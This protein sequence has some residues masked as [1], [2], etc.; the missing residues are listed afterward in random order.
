M[1]LGPSLGIRTIQTQQL[2]M[3]PQLQQAIKLLALTNLELEN[4][5]QAEV[6]NNP[7]LDVA[8]ADREDGGGDPDEAGPATPGEATGEGNEELA[9][10][11]RLIESGDAVAD[12]PLEADYWGEGDRGAD[13]ERFTGSLDTG[14]EGEGLADIESL[15]EQRPTLAEHLLQQAAAVLT[16]ANLAV[17][18][19][20]I[21]QIDDSGYF[22]GDLGE[23]AAALGVSAT[24][25]E[26]ILKMIQGFDPTGVGART[27]GECLELQAREAGVLTRPM[28]T[29]IQHL[30]LLAKGEAMVLRRL[31]R[32]RNSE[33]LS[34]LVRTLRS[35][36]PKPGAGFGPSSASPVAP[37]VF[38]TRTARGWGI[39]LNSA[40]MPRLLINRAYYAELVRGA[41]GTEKQFLADCLQSANWLTKALDQRARTII[42]VVAE[43]VR[44]QEGFFEHGVSRLKPLNLRAVAEV[45]QMHESTISRVTSNKYLACP[46]GIF[47]LK[48]FFTPA[49]QLVNT[50]DGAISTEA[51]K[52]RLRALIEAES[53]DDVLSDDKLVDLLRGEGFDVARR[54]VAKYREAMHIGSSVQRRR[55]LALSA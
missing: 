21:D 9:P 45:V 52:R 14:P 33:E 25:A 34:A 22:R 30:D 42:K 50:D 1:A 11:D 41:R 26:S 12:A 35:F 38:V 47:E 44:Q 2:V 37:D 40:T 48:Y 7:L 18:R 28:A 49:L 51:V 43:I 24:R 32:L 55:M 13:G 17:A 20:L 31:C 27:V 19:Y 54:T 36:N 10:A 16:D 5:V 6:E 39:E 3:T 23:T 15:A 53:A 8:G 46:R 29:L 4:F